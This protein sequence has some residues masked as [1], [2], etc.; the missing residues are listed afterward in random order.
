[1]PLSFHAS[2]SF[3]RPQ[4]H[5]SL[6]ATFHGPNQDEAMD[7]KT[8]SGRRIAAQRNDLGLK[9]RE[10]CALVPGLTVTRLSNWEKGLR[11]ISVDEAKRLAPVLKTSAG[12]LLTLD[13]VPGDPRER[14]LLEKYRLCDE[15]GRQTLHRVAEA[16]CPYD[17][18][19][20]DKGL[21]ASG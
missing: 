14:A 13:D 4:I 7:T 15:R 17:V 3:A 6:I 9:Q 1:M 20:L 18:S 19:P 21:A 10:V 5:K 2:W 11:M 12:Y 8:E 16:E